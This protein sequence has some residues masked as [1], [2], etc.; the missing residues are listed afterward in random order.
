MSMMLHHISYIRAL[1]IAIIIINSIS[2]VTVER[3]VQWLI[4]IYQ[5]SIAKYLQYCSTLIKF[6]TSLELPEVKKL[7]QSFGQRAFSFTGTAQWNL[8]PYRL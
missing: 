6:L 7:C 3:L 8:L 1:L 2:R 5:K 4:Y